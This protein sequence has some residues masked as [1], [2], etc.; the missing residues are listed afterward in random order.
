MDPRWVA[1]G[2]VKGRGGA[3]LAE[4][5]PGGGP[6]R[7]EGSTV[8]CVVTQILASLLLVEKLKPHVLRRH[9]IEKQACACVLMSSLSCALLHASQC[10]TDLTKENI[11]PLTQLFLLKFYPTDKLTQELNI[12]LHGSNK[13]QTLKP[14]HCPS[15]MKTTGLPLKRRVWGEL[16]AQT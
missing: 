10:V 13:R 1:S 9:A 14:P 16:F 8:S 2:C 3:C 5:G 4:G 11:S 7:P 6:G 12:G 15:R